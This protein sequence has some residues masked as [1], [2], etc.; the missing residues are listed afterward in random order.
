MIACV[1]S[2]CS[3]RVPIHDVLVCGIHSRFSISTNAVSLACLSFLRRSRIKWESEYAEN[4][5]DL[6]VPTY[7]FHCSMVVDTIVSGHRAMPAAADRVPMIQR[8]GWSAKE[9]GCGGF[10]ASWLLLY[11]KNTLV[12]LCFINYICLLAYLYLLHGLPLHFYFCYYEAP[13]TKI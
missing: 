9:G 4:S 3:E 11:T 10:R 6:W 7:F 12:C 2:E 8:V 13:P 5:S 1:R